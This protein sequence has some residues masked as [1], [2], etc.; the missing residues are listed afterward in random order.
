MKRPP[1]KNELSGQQ[2]DASLRRLD[3]GI[4]GYWVLSVVG[5]ILFSLLL[6]PAGG[7]PGDGE[8]QSPLMSRINPN[9]APMGSLIRLDGIGPARAH[10][11]IE[12][13]QQHSQPGGAAFQLPGDLEAIRGIGPKTVEKLSD[14]LVF[15]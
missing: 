1:R 3:R 6:A 14:E 10:D 5:L 4:R 2:G 12:Y 8:A 7:R 11:M 13:R 15:D 9:T